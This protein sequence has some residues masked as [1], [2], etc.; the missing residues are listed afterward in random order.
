MFFGVQILGKKRP[1]STAWL[2]GCGKKFNR[3]KIMKENILETCD[4]IMQ[5]VVPLALR[6]SAV[7]MSGVIKCFHRKQQYTLEDCHEAV[8][9]ARSLAK[10]AKGAHAEGHVSGATVRSASRRRGGETTIT[11]NEGTAINEVSKHVEEII[12][13]EFLSTQ[14]PSH[15]GMMSSMDRSLKSVELLSTDPSSAARK[16]RLTASDTR[17]SLAHL[18]DRVSLD[19]SLAHG[20]PSDDMADDMTFNGHVDAAMAAATD[21]EDDDLLKDFFFV[22]SQ[23]Q[24]LPLSQAQAPTHTGGPSHEDQDMPPPLEVAMPAD[25]PHAARE[26]PARK[27][28]RRAQ[29]YRNDAEAML[30]RQTIRRWIGSARDIICR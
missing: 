24:E 20:G 13:Q 25:S 2:L 19:G 11:Y 7:L 8:R 12:L 28:R 9:T 4:M 10:Y 27:R 23:Q 15:S 1:L 3:R 14:H 21:Q 16:R 26:Q 22:G 18:H 30:P 5:P 6:L 17:S 29:G